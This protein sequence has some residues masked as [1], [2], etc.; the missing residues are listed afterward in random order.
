MTALIRDC[1]V[2]E[3]V[4][5]LRRANA[6]RV[7]DVAQ[8]RAGDTVVVHQLRCCCHDPLPGGPPLGGKPVRLGDRFVRCH[9]VGQVWRDPSLRAPLP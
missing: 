1:L 9:Q 2:L 7:V 3:V 4:I 8:T 6:G 5:H